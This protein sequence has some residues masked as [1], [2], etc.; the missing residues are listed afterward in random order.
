M[1]S[2]RLSV[3][4]QRPLLADAMLDEED[5]S[6]PPEESAV[7]PVVRVQVFDP[8]EETTY[9]VRAT[10]LRPSFFKRW[11]LTPLISL[12]TG[13]IFAVCLY[14]KP[15]LQKKWLYSAP[16]SIFTATHVYVEGKGK[17]LSRS[18]NILPCCVLFDR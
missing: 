6:E 9:I 13:L 5:G 2:D 15:N 12:L 17:A 18:R 10:L 7:F 1:F 14:W 8:Q 11:V 4:K 16:N 3:G